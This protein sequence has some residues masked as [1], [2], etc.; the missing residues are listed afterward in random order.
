MN[1]SSSGTVIHVDETEFTG[2]KYS[3]VISQI[4]QVNVRNHFHTVRARL[5]GTGSFLCFVFAGISFCFIKEHFP[6][7]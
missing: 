3:R 4:N 5:E 1:H 7:H 2:C 6:C